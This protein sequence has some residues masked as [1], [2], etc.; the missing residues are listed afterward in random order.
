MPRARELFKSRG[1]FFLAHILIALQ[2][3][4]NCA[5]I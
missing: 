4:V 2:F 1:H 3:I 5:Q